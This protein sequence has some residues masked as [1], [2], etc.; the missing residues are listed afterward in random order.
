MFIIIVQKVPSEGPISKN[1]SLHVK[2]K[3]FHLNFKFFF[4]DE[5]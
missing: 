1:C 3:Q 5:L 2:F 4:F